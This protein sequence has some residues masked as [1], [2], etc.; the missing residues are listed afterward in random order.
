[1]E[2]GKKNIKQFVKGSSILIASNIVLKGIQFF[3]LPLYTK[4]LSPSELGISDTITAFTS[5]LF[6]LLVMA[7]DS[8]FS[9]FYFEKGNSKEHFEHVFNTVFF[10]L[11][12]QSII[13]IVLIAGSDAISEILFQSSE[14]SLA[15]TI[16]LISVSVNL[17]YLPFSLL[18]RMQNRMQIFAVINVL[19]SLLMICFNVLFLT[20]FHLGYLSLLLST[21]VVYIIQLLLYII[22]SH[23]SVGRRF[24]NKDLKK[25][26]LKYALPYLPTTVATWILTMSDRYMI[27]FFCGNAEVGVYG[28]G[29]RYMTVVSTIISGITTAYTTFAFQNEKEENA[30]EMYS[31]LLNIVFVLLG[32]ICTTIALFGKEINSLMTTGDYSSSYVL[33]GGLMFGQLLYAMNTLVGYGI[34][35]KKKSKYYFYSVTA[36]AVFNIILNYL[37]IPKMRSEGATIASLLGYLLMFIFT[38]YYAQ[39]VYPC[40]YEMKKIIPCLAMLILT[41]VIFRET[42]IFLKSMIWCLD[43]AIVLWIFKKSI[44]EFLCDVLK[45]G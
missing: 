12:I 20:V 26:M 45:K 24:Y 41:S 27:L 10:F 18:V 7:F 13:P 43:A 40:K 33:L 8:A 42:N 17:W 6:P 34:A 5:F 37:L 30:K 28:I 21:C 1:M 2:R 35:F 22:T 32:G 25:R 11:V 29:T 23:I 3:L 14:Y 38:Y 39:K 15:V 44:R 16:A 4:Y 31:K 19:S 36:G 9:A